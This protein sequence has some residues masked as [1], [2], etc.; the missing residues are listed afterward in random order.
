MDILQTLLASWQVRHTRR[1]KDAFLSFAKEYGE[2]LGYP[3]RVEENKGWLM[4]R[5]FVAGDPEKAKIVLTAHYDTCSRMPFPNKIF[6]DHRHLSLLIQMCWIVPLALF[7]A[8][9]GLLARHFSGIDALY[10]PVFLTTYFGIFALLFFGPANP[11]TANDNTSGVAAILAIMA[12]LPEEKRKE[13]A[14][15][16]FDNEEYGLVG[17]K[18]YNKA[19]KDAMAEKPLF[20]LDCV[21]DGDR[22]YLILP[23]DA[24]EA[25][26]QRYRAAFPAEN[27]FSVTLRRADKT[28]YNS[29]QRSFPR[30]AALAAFHQGRFGSTLGRIHT[31]RDT[32]CSEQNLRFAVDGAL[33][34]IDLT[35]KE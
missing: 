13:A 12:A 20:N 4:C 22:M 28:R 18:A 27:G 33:R 21:G 17:S 11:H 1:Q 15:I 31:K 2:K 25:T 30:G 16:L 19:H 34:L 24:D 10:P 35:S 26:E 6:P 32:V 29:D 9:L 23:K 14:F 8:G 3:C 7:C 5:N